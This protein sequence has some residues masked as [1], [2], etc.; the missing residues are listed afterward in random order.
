MKFLKNKYRLL[1]IGIIAVIF[2]AE[3]LIMLI[4]PY[5]PSFRVG[6]KTVLDAFLLIILLST[7]LYL[8]FLKPLLHSRKK[9][10][11]LQDY[12]E[13]IHN[14]SGFELSRRNTGEEIDVQE[15][16][17][18][19]FA[20]LCGILLL[21]FMG[22][23]VMFGIISE[24]KSDSTVINQAGA[25]RMLSQKITKDVLWLL[26][27]KR[28]N[29]KQLKTS[30]ERFELVLDGLKNGSILLG[31]PRCK[32]EQT[33]SQ[34]KVV[35]S[36]WLSFKKNIDAIVNNGY[37]SDAEIDDLLYTSQLLLS[38]MDAAVKLF[39]GLSTDKVERMKFVQFAIVSFTSALIFLSWVF[40]ILPLTSSFKEVVDVLRVRTKE[41]EKAKTAAERANE[42]KSK[43]L[44]NMS[45]E[46]RTPMNGIMGFTNILMESNPTEEQKEFL[47]IIQ[48]SANNL[49]EIIND[50]LDIS[51]VEAEKIILEEAEFEIETII[52]EI[53]NLIKFKAHSGTEVFADVGDIP[54]MLLGDST[55]L[56]QIITNLMGNACKFTQSGEITL[57]VSLLSDNDEIVELQ[58]V[59]QDTGIGIPEEKLNLI[60]KPFTQA[61]DSVTR[62]FG[63]T[64]LGLS[65]SKKFSEL[66]G[67][68]MWVESIKGKGSIF[69]FTAKFKKANSCVKAHAPFKKTK[70]HGKHAIVV[71]DSK[72]SL[73]ITGRM[74][75]EFCVTPKTF[76][77][78]R[79][80]IEY[81]KACD[82][83]PDFGIIDMTMPEINGL[84]FMR[85]IQKDERLS[86]IP[87]II[88]ITDSTQGF[89]EIYEKVGYT[90]YLPKLIPKQSFL[91]II[92]SAI[93]IKKG[94]KRVI[95]AKDNAKKEITA[96]K[97]NTRKKIIA[98][99]SNAKKEITAA[100]SKAKEEILKNT[101]ILLTE[102][103]KINQKLMVKMLTKLGCKVDIAENGLVALNKLKKER[104]YDLILMDIQMPEMDGISATKEIRKIGIDTPIVAMTANAMKGDRK[105]CMDAGMSD[106]IAKP[107]KQNDV[108]DK[109][110]RWRIVR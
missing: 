73:G 110:Q 102:D 89:G 81:L 39:E 82:K 41:M 65:I 47:E 90:S 95:A 28:S 29:T 55:R 54:T 48:K 83:L 85:I 62:K 20:I 67:G 64:G 7:L 56:R 18:K 66:M 6:T 24:H 74:L 100:K 57:K 92:C 59:V 1:F 76:N 11:E 93:D 80:A 99:K 45:H 34:L 108:I 3:A 22:V 60:F 97:D 68:K 79:Y 30:I 49:L 50:I 15:L 44:A 71:D 42:T 78:A 10:K 38:E 63:G 16:K 43:F 23:L 51:K 13:A 37:K 40:L 4:L 27:T 46:I 98:A 35:E 72:T 88:H 32:D 17:N 21:S 106:Y 69:Y 91:D 26:V 53:C 19:L 2:I 12:K 9:V 52:Y 87:M 31:L 96:V 75:Q 36:L 8:S 14:N 5:F 77:E 86:K 58:F 94:K 33:L 104:N 109:I 107:I 84:E 103:N 101:Y 105:N 70:L 25:Q 61:D